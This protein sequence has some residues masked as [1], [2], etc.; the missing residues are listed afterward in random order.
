MILRAR[1]V[2]PICTPPIEDGVVKL[3]GKQIIS[4]G[5]W[6]DLP[7]SERAEVTDLG[8][9]VLLPGLVNA[10][11]HLDY[12]SMAGKLL[13]PRRFSNWVQSLVSLKATWT[14]QDF[15][16]SWL[17]GAEMLL[18]TG[19]TTVLDVEAVPSLIPWIWKETPL[20]VISFR[21]LISLKDSPESRRMVGNGDKRVA[22]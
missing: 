4:M 1:A 8:E 11:C 17:S 14:E 20:R 21:E 3:R 12:T 22:I 16:T 9:S 2:L 10:H 7:A 18:R 6:S 19:T 13:P 5:R 15:S